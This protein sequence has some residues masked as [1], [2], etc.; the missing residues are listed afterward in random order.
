MAL[1]GS[2]P[3]SK[4]QRHDHQH[5][6]KH[7]C[8][9]ERSQADD[10]ELRQFVKELESSFGC[11]RPVGDVRGT[12][13]PCKP[14]RAY[15][16]SSVST[17]GSMTQLFK[18]DA[19]AAVADVVE[20]EPADRIDWKP[21]RKQWLAMI[22]LSLVS[23]V[24]SL[25][26]TILV[27]ALPEISHSLRGSAA[28]TFWT[29]TAYLLISAVFQPVIAAA[30]ACCGRQRLLVMSIVLFTFGTAFC[31]VAHDFAV[32]LI[33]RCVQ[34]V[35]GGGVIA[36]TQ[37]IFCDMVP[38]RQRPQYFSM[39]LASWSIGS[40]IGPVIGGAFVESA[41]WRWC[42]YINFPF[43]FLGFFAALLFVDDVDLPL[44][45][46]PR[47]MDW[48][49]AFLFVG[50]TT[51][52][53]LGI[54]WGGAQHPWASAVTLAPIFAGVLGIAGFV[55]WQW[56]AQP[57]SLLPIS[58][59]HSVSSAAAFFCALVNGL[60][61]F[62][63][64]YY[65]PF[66]QMSVRGSSPVRAG[67]DLFPAVCLLVPGSVV[68]A[69]LTS[70]LGRFRW[71]IWLGWSVTL[72]ACGLFTVLNERTEK[73]IFAFALAVFGVGNGMVLTSVNVATQAIANQTV[74]KKEDRAMAACM[75]G[76]MRSLGMPVGVALSGTVF[77]NAMGAALSDAGLSTDIA[78]DSERYIFILHSMADADP[79]K[80]ALLSSYSRGFHAVFVAM[81]VISAAALLASLFIRRSGM[82]TVRL[83]V[84]QRNHV[85]N[86]WVCRG[87]RCNVHSLRPMEAN[88]NITK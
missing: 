39:V 70:R 23:F 55:A 53:L 51:S 46:H 13:P 30:S 17:S 81:T 79:R 49:G 6:H 48:L 78:R 47:R 64:L 33:G 25:D 77:Q 66:Y 19:E 76:F 27:T 42:F 16:K 68:V 7:N 12:M 56:R 41:S 83:A 62:I 35:G 21:E 26:A 84:P 67:I 38:L 11:D 9:P 8:W 74:A 85:D 50:S 31:A 3:S 18:L 36:M 69:I 10:Y 22:S 54:S 52:L 73:A 44:A 82:D 2:I 86:E 59:L 15:T 28:E 45:D 60:I 75:Y 37:V 61:L 4:E 80:S 57:H 5:N 34:G 29:G 1:S 20:D 88:Q 24:V 43:C 87:T 32:M 65:V 40:I 63:G 72:V 14:E 58:L 71:A